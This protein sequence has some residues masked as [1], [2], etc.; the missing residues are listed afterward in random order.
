MA[1]SNRSTNDS[2]AAGKRKASE[3]VSKSKASAA[4]GVSK[5][6]KTK[7][8]KVTKGSLANMNMNPEV[9]AAKWKAIN[10]E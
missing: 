8:V 10:A 6:K 5:P 7:A 1:P 2:P 4:A 9:V 3:N